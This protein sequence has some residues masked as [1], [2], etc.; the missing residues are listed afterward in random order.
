MV[1][2]KDAG[3]LT[4]EDIE[5]LEKWQKA[6]GAEEP[7]KWSGSAMVFSDLVK[8]IEENGE[9][10]TASG[11]MINTGDQI[12]DPPENEENE[13]TLDLVMQNISSA[14]GEFTQA[15]KDIKSTVEDLKTILKIQTPEPAGPAQD[16]EPDNGG[17]PPQDKDEEEDTALTAA[18]S[19]VGKSHEPVEELKPGDLE[20]ILSTVVEN[21]MPQIRETTRSAVNSQ[22]GVVD[23]TGLTFKPKTN[24][25]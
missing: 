8:Q 9:I 14:M 3:I 10:G 2:A 6:P 7:R 18:L 21:M 4:N 12:D 24:G 5:I 22:L 25:G 19:E 23:P 15:V 1:R 17:T 13:V 11:D 16:A 20:R